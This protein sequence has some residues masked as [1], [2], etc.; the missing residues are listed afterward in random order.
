MTG[1]LR[2]ALS[3]CGWA[4]RQAAKAGLFL[5]AAGS[6]AA[7]PEADEIA[8][9]LGYGVENSDSCV[10]DGEGETANPVTGKCDGG[11][12]DFYAV[13]STFHPY[14]KARGVYFE[15]FDWDTAEETGFE[16]NAGLVSGTTRLDNGCVA[17]PEADLGGASR[18]AV[19]MYLDA[20][21]QGI[22]VRV[23]GDLDSSDDFGTSNEPHEAGA[24]VGGRCGTNPLDPD[25]DGTGLLWCQPNEMLLTV[26]SG[27]DGM[28]QAV[29]A[30]QRY[31]VAFP[32]NELGTI[33]ALTQFPV[34]WW[35]QNI[36]IINSIDP[37]FDP[38]EEVTITVTHRN[39]NTQSGCTVEFPCSATGW[40]HTD[41]DGRGEIEINIQTI[42]P[43]YS[44]KFLVGHEV[45]HAMEMIWS[46]FVLNVASSS[47]LFGADG[48]DL[49]DAD[50]PAACTTAGAVVSHGITTV[51]HVSAAANEGFA[52]F[53]AA[54]VYNDHVEED[55]KFNY[56]KLEDIFGFHEDVYL[57][58]V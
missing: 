36:D 6:A 16:P 20:K 11:G 8:I 1:G 4:A 15:V 5:F 33:M 29:E 47:A 14:W 37:Q 24:S 45:G 53:F 43:R 57:D 22:T 55:G 19:R 41:L 31:N 3:A 42:W 49:D 21:L 23:R 2:K 56:Y 17:I 39:L 13:N 35:N 28:P 38:N 30:G 26:N 54:D 48:Y 32:Q 10:N 27:N 9:C 18:L 12:D 44:R 50:H 51:E 52:H 34:F 40:I 58:E 7:F 46:R 25:P